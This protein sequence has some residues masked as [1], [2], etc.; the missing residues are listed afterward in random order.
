LGYAKLGTG[1]SLTDEEVLKANVNIW[2]QKMVISLDQL[3]IY[4]TFKEYPVCTGS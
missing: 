3:N 4:K 2:F 1:T